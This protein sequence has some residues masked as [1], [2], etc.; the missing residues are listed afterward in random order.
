MVWPVA[1]IAIL[2]W[3]IR[4]RHATTILFALG[5]QV[6]AGLAHLHARGGGDV[7]VL[8][9]EGVTAF[10]NNGFVGPL[11]IALAAVV[12][13]R[14]MHRDQKGVVV[15]TFGWLGLI[16]AGLWW[17][18]AWCSEIIRVLPMLQVSAALIATTVAT[19]WLMNTLSNRLD[20]PQ[21]LKSTAVYLPVLVLIAMDS[22]Q[23]GISHPLEGW[24]AL[25]WPAALVMHGFLLRWQKPVLE[26]RSLEAAHIGGAWLFLLLFSL[27]LWWWANQL[28]DPTSAWPL[29]GMVLAPVLYIWILTRESVQARWPVS[30]HHHGYVLV[31]VVPVAV[32]LMGWLWDTNLHSA[33]SA[34]PLVYL[35]LLNPLE[36]GYLA[37]MFVGTVWWR[38]AKPGF[39][40]DETG[41][42]TNATL[43][44]TAFAL[45]TGGI[46][47]AC[48]HWARHYKG[49]PSLGE[50][51]LETGYSVGVL[52]G[53]DI[54]VDS[55]GI[56]RHQ[57][58]ALWQS[59]PQQGHLDHWQHFSGY[60]GR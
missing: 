59:P 10:L 50:Y 39:G 30:E 36:L 5:L 15:G 1:G 33:G 31:S 55:L 20:W 41:R 2:I 19:A 3:A 38:A 49:L 45:L 6:V 53:A 23:R 24:N 32:F 46:I 26:S 28:F 48:H 21:L 25:A 34:Q 29:L 52:H 11:I 17:G 60:R 43:A 8:I 35:P 4:A 22:N 40:L 18:L 12:C 56:A 9:P 51:T 42:I 27:E 37:V 47:R 57:L 54:P 7:T 44:V 13:A 14:L 16:W 58:H